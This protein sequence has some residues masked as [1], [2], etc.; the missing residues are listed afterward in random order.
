MCLRI[1]SGGGRRRRRQHRCGDAAGR[2]HVRAGRSRR[3]LLGRNKPQFLRLWAAKKVCELQSAAGGAGRP[4]GA[5]IAAYCSRYCGCNEP[6]RGRE[7]GHLEG[8]RHRRRAAAPLPC[9]RRPGRFPGRFR[10]PS[11]LPG[12]FPATGEIPGK[13][14]G[15]REPGKIPGKFPGKFPGN[16]GLP[17]KF[18]ASSLWALPRGWASPWRGGIRFCPHDALRPS[19]ALLGAMPALEIRKPAP[20]A[21]TGFAFA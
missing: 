3:G 14:A 11:R 8:V 13:F 6:Q 12:P 4:E 10:A 18:R 15:T 21:F 5:L 1:A 19:G 17:G 7:G 9:R 16:S 2:M 20:I